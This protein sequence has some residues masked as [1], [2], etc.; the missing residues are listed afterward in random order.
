MT[1]SQH[2]NERT[3][4]ACALRSKQARSAMPTHLVA[5]HK[6]HLRTHHRSLHDQ[7]LGQT[8]AAQVST[9]TCYTHIISIDIQL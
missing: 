6:R 1:I 4:L 7:L 3:A 8:Q 9:N 2:A 5:A